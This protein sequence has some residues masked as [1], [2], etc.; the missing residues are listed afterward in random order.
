MKP[1]FWLLMVVFS[2]VAGEKKSEI[3]LNIAQGGLLSTKI[4]L[5][6]LGSMGFKADM[7]RFT[8]ADGRVEMDLVLSGKKLFDPK[9]FI[10]TLDEHQIRLE[11]RPFKNKQ[12]TIGLDATNAFWHLPAISEDEGAQ[13]EHTNLPYWF[14]VD[15]A[16]GISVEAPY[17]NKWYP[18]IA[19]FDN[20]MQ[21]L[22]SFRELKPRDRMSFKL[23]E[24]AVYLKIS[25]ANGMKMLK[26]G[27]WV[28]SANDEQQ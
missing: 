23:P 19:V 15:K 25:N 20:N 6:V 28:E 7:H 14:V 24:H 21:I 12:L 26:E 16:L 8:S 9:E 1:L 4:I 17:G 18:E 10:E 27:M 2:L 5:H 3:H 22:G 13:L 11:S